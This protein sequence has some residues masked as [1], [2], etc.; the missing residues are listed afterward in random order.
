MTDMENEYLRNLAAEGMIVSFAVELLLVGYF[1]EHPAD[2]REELFDSFLQ[3]AKRTD[4]FAGLT[5]GNEAESE[6]F[7]DVLVRA[8]QAADTLIARVKRRLEASAFLR[9][10]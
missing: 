6:F 3:T 2:E 5:K 9:D 7:A 4:H 1:K 10:E 8:H